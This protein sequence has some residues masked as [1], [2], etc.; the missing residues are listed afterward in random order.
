MP[1][2][3]F[4]N[5][6]RKSLDGPILSLVTTD[7]PDILILIEYPEVTMLPALLAATG[8]DRVVGSSR[9]G[10]F[11][12]PGFSLTLEPNPDPTDRVNFWRVG[13]Q[14]GDDW[15][16]VIL[17][18]PD[19]R[20]APQDD[21]RQYWFRRIADH[22]RFLEN[23]AGHRRTV[24]LGDFNA[25]PFDPSV[26]GA[27]GFHAVGVRRVRGQFNRAVRNAG[28]AEFFYNPMWRLYGTDPAGDAGAG[29]YYY[30]GYE[31]TEPFWHMPDQVLIRP[32]VADRLPA[33]RLRIL[34]TAG[35]V[36]LVDADGVPDREAASDHL[37]IVFTL[38]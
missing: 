22:A 20:N 9:F 35:P 25:N 13:Q 31:A 29:T 18:G 8:F 2:V 34:S 27:N 3:L 23:Q 17:H 10:V 12:R 28:R 21:T 24:I 37:P 5:V 36:S 16:V 7:H 30:H 6:Q 4:W 14:G 11:A 15:L 19:R 32:E 26:L 33:E 38:T 1:R